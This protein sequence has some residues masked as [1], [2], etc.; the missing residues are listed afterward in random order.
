MEDWMNELFSIIVNW[1]AV[2]AIVSMTVA[3]AVM[4]MAVVYGVLRGFF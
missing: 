4:A 2:S 1:C 3:L